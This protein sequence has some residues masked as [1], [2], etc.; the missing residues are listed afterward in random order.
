MKKIT[1][2][3][4][5]FLAFFTF[6][7]VGCTKQNPLYD[8]VSELR[9]FLYEGKSEN[10]NLKASYGF[11][12]TPYTNDAVVG[13][14]AYTLSFRLEEKETDNATYSLELSLDGIT[15]NA[16]FKLNP[17]THTL[18][19]SVELENFNRNEFLVTIHSGSTSQTINMNSI[20]PS[21]TIDYKT[22]LDHLYKDQ[23]QLLSVYTD[24][25]GN[26]NAEIYA[27]IVVKN[28]KPYWYIG[29][30]SGNGN[31]K[32]LLIDGFTGETLAIREIF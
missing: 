12:E 29:I 30:A 27:R 18:S 4:A 26:F 14:R 24:S 17:I 25:N 20:I 19:A 11:K 2:L 8:K 5:L 9:C 7:T 32:A 16:D 23:T 6:F 31:L 10:F 1:K 21:G 15:Y 13:E 3:I 28:L 22:A